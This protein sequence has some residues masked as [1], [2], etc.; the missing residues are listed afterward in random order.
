MN[1]SN[2]NFFRQAPDDRAFTLRELLVVLAVMTLLAAAFFPALAKSGPEGQS[3]TCLNA[4]R[5]LALAWLMYTDDNNGRLVPN[6]QGAQ[7]QGGVG[8]A[9]LGPGYVEGWLD[10]TVSSDNTNALLISATRYSKLGPYLKGDTN[11]FKCPT[12]QFLS[13]LQKTRGWTQRIRSVSL[14]ACF[15]DGNAEA[16]AWDTSYHH[17]KKLSDIRYP[18]PA[19]CFTFIDEHPDSINDALIFL[20]HSNSWVDHPAAL[21][22]GAAGIA[23]GDGHAE[24]HRWTASVLKAALVRYTFVPVPVTFGDPDLH[25][26]SYHSPRMTTNSY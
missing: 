7:A 26:V 11:A 17:L 16:G 25:W 4:K 14:S 21:H 24:I 5:Q 8:S 10:W 1:S 19:E 12:D 20:P 13:A 3:V 9:L 23:M 6:L 15:G 18:T 22:E 2:P